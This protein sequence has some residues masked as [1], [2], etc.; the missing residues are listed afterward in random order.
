MKIQEID[1]GISGIY[2]IIFDDGGRKP[3]V[4]IGESKCIK[5]RWKQHINRLKGGY[6][7]NM[8]LKNVFNKHG[9]SHF[10][11]KVFEVI[12]GSTQKERFVREKFWIKELKTFGGAKTYN[13]YGFNLTEGGD[14]AGIGS[15]NHQAKSCEVDGV[16]YGTYVEVADIYGIPK[17][18]VPSRIKST[19]L[20]FKDW[21][22]VDDEGNVIPKDCNPTK[23]DKSKE[24]KYILEYKNKKSEHVGWVVTIPFND[25]NSKRVGNFKLY[26]KDI[27]RAYRDYWL[28][29]PNKSLFVDVIG[30]RLKVIFHNDNIDLIPKS[31]FKKGIYFDKISNKY[32]SQIT[33]NKKIY[34]LGRYTDPQEAS[35]MH[36]FA[37]YNYVLNGTLPLKSKDQYKLYLE[38]KEKGSEHPIINHLFE[39][40]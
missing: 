23:Y 12:D 19:S 7:K 33:I 4:Y 6:H 38:T 14:G 30:E 29:H 28:E 8:H 10:E 1:Y 3:L 34:R 17:Y 18:V 37:L 20:R 11:F 15:N 25:L 32:R 31:D 16:R 13:G 36:Y 35:K 21:V 22:G 26:E 24:D 9:W 39:S 40:E 27:A 2:H 5:T